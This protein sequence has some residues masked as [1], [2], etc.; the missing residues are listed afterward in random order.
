MKSRVLYVLS[1]APA[2][3]NDIVLWD[4]YHLITNPKV[5]EIVASKYDKSYY[6]T[7][8][9]DQGRAVNFVAFSVLPR[10]RSLRAA[11]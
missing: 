9:D 1:S 2:V 10:S 7:A 4:I 11:A 3:L 5:H 8:L 6:I